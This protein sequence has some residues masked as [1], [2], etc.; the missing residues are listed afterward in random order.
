MRFM[1][2]V[3]MPVDTANEAVRNGTLGKT[4]ESIL[5]DTKP[6]AAYFL[7]DNGQRTGY[8]FF[9][10]KETSDIPS[11]AEPW[12]LALNASIELHPAMNIEDLKKAAP[13]MEQA[14]RKYGRPRTATART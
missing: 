12:F 13:G 4:I 6:E 1:L 5:A 9:D 14:S 11:I 3:N 8:I 2:K 7:D 10:M